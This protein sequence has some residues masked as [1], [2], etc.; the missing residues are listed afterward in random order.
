MTNISSAS[1]PMLLSKWFFSFILFILIEKR[2]GTQ[3]RV[4]FKA[5]GSNL[6]Q[7]CKNQE[8]FDP[9]NLEIVLG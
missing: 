8:K 5:K 1:F 6:S 9:A 3:A 4:E 2:S 7:Y